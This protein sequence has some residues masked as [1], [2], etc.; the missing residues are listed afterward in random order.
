M[1]T[2]TVCVTCRNS[3]SRAAVTPTDQPRDGEAFLDS[4]RAAAGDIPVRGVS[5]LMGC[6][7]GCNIAISAGGKMTYVLGRFDGT[8]ED[9]TAIADY[10]SKHRDSDTGLVRFKEWHPGVKGHFIA[11]VPPLD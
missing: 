8:T 7:Q 1:T 3:D 4:V 10:A 2:I 5:C 6:E 11:R 9:A